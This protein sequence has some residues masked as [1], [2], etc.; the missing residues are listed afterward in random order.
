VSAL[1]A[2]R[3]NRPATQIDSLLY[4]GDPA[5]DAAFVQLAQEL[6]RL[7]SAVRGNDAPPPGGQQ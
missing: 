6:P 5:D 4:G 7:E 1:V 2:E 3:S